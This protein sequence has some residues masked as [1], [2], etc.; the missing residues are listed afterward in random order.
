MW[1]RRIVQAANGFTVEAVGLNK[2][3]R[4]QKIDWA[5]PDLIIFDDIDEKHDTPEATKKKAEIITG[6]H[7]PGRV[8]Q[9]RRAVR[10]EPHS[11]GQASPQ[12]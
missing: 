11:P 6:S 9:C 12:R 7:S 1:N 8:N 5:R 4:G 3:V 10:A 2:A